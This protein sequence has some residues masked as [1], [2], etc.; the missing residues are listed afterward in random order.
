MFIIPMIDN[1]VPSIENHQGKVKYSLP[2]KGNWVVVNGG[3]TKALSHSWS[4][5][6]QRYAYDF[7]KLDENGKSYAGDEMNLDSYYC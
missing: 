7:I 4:I 3:I 1:P 2:L 5:N 6:S